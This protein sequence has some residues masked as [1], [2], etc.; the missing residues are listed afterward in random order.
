MI[1][2]A[3]WNLRRANALRALAL[4][5]ALDDPVFERVKRDYREPAAGCKYID[6]TRERRLQS[7]QFL[8]RGNA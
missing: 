6:C 2:D 7:H 4:D 1:A 3:D 8:I 5:E